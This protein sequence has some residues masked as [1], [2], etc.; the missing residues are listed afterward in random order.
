M[1]ISMD[2][3]SLSAWNALLSSWDAWLLTFT[4]VVIVPTLGYL[5]FRRLENQSSPVPSSRLKLTVYARIILLQWFLVAA[6]LLIGWRHGLSAADV[7]EH[8]GDARLTL[9]VTAGLVAIVAV[10]D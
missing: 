1:P 7:G 4:L 9:G 2:P 5:R 8:L 6:M 10:V 3:R